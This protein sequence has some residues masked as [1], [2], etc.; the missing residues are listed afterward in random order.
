MI[1]VTPELQVNCFQL[2]FLID[3]ISKAMPFKV[4][5]LKVVHCTFRFSPKCA[6]VANCGLLDTGIMYSG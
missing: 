4:L 2:A 3:E 1:A 6:K 5:K